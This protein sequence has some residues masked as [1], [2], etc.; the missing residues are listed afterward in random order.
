MKCD[1]CGQR[2]TIPRARAMRRDSQKAFDVRKFVGAARGWSVVPEPHGACTAL[3][4]PTGVYVK[5][6]QKGADR[7][8]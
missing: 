5:F 2:D 1:R 4:H 3:D 6:T 8:A 7:F